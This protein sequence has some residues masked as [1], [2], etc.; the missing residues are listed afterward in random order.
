MVTTN[1][2]SDDAIRRAVE[3]SERIAKFAPDD[4]EAMPSLP[5][6][7]Y[8]P[9]NAYFDSTANLS[10][11]DRARAAL[12]ALSMA[13][14]AGD[15][16]AAGYLVTGMASVALDNKAGPAPSVPASAH[17]PMRDMRGRLSRAPPTN[18]ASTNTSAAPTRHTVT[19]GPP[20]SRALLASVR[21][22]ATASIHSRTLR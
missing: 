3:Q 10:P 1:D 4:P 13:R 6:Q 20:L 8:T 12:V 2:L 17:V 18:T 19:D 11:E 14:D 21:S 16:Y 15:L 22:A 9:V 7:S 5:R